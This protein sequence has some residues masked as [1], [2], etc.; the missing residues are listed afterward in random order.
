MLLN[1]CDT[2][3]TAK[4]LEIIGGSYAKC[5]YL[6]CNIKRYGTLNPNFK[7]FYDYDN[8][9]VIGKYFEDSVHAFVPPENTAQVI[10]FIKTNSPRTIF[11]SARLESLTDSFLEEEVCIY[12]LNKKKLPQK[13]PS[14]VVCEL[15]QKD[16]PQL[17]S[18]LMQNSE[19]YRRTYDENNLKKQFIERMGEKYSRFFGL[20]KDDKLSGCA[21]TKAEI[22]D[23]IIVGG[24]L[25][26]PDH[27]N[28]GLGYLLCCK[29]AFVAKNEN[30]DAYCF[31][32][33]N[34]AASKRLHT[35]VGYE[36]VEKVYKYTKK[37]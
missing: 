35:K 18:F 2:S 16:I 1:A 36:E 8:K 10:D 14:E 4:A 5:L 28:E 34:L 3:Q 11:S 26:S 23:L 6:Y 9:T 27:R 13:D 15:G 31:V 37:I 19:T 30:K 25:V 7:V 32:E 12:K 33:K 20:Y 17:V 22:S 29:K 24:I 21:F